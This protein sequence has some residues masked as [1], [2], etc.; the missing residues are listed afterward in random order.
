M[1]TERK[2]WQIGLESGWI[3]DV[4][5]VRKIVVVRGGRSIRQ[6]FVILN[7]I[8]VVVGEESISMEETKNEKSKSTLLSV[9]LDW[10]KI[11]ILSFF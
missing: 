2:F 10:G 7:S 5:G 3:V 6:R 11:F 1:F 9:P 8:K 4:L